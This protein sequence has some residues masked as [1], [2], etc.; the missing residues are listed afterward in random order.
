[1]SRLRKWIILAV[2]CLL[3][4]AAVV[5]IWWRV[6]KARLVEESQD[7]AKC[8]SDGATDT[9]TEHY[10]PSNSFSLTPEL[11]SVRR[12]FVSD[13]LI[14]AKEPSLAS[15]IG[16][17]GE[18]YRF[19]LIHTNDPPVIVRVWRSGNTAQLIAKQFN[20][21]GGRNFGVV[22]IENTRP[23]SE[24]EWDT[25]R[26]LVDRALFWS[27]PQTD[28]SSPKSDIG[29]LWV[30]EAVRMGQHRVVSRWM[31]RDESYRKCGLY[32]LTISGLEIDE[33][34]YKVE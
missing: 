6:H 32:L 8:F 17:A 7:S 4:G 33:Q 2:A 34:R 18:S 13:V 3:I 12:A 10:F 5:A 27:L 23:I 14:N 16:C 19:L 11:E 22:A 25:F 20:G 28:A 30:F 26:V 29:S 9:P 21:D 1:M 15:F 31:P 24:N